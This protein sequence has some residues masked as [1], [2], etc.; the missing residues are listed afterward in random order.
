L[1]VAEHL[2]H[3]VLNEHGKLEFWQRVATHSLI[4]AEFRRIARHNATLVEG[5][6]D[7]AR[8]LPAA[9]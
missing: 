1:L 5:F 3:E 2:A 7:A 4:L 6:R 9:R 8:L